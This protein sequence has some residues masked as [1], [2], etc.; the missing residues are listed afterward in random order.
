MSLRSK[1]VTVLFDEVEIARCGLVRG[2]PH[3]TSGQ[4]RARSTRR[5]GSVVAPVHRVA[6]MT[7]APHYFVNPLVCANL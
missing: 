5:L 1:S 4:S 2:E 6:F 3:E 7:Q